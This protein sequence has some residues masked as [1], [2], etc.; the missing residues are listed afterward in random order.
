MT[1]E[2]SAWI[3][4][5]QAW[6]R[7]GEKQMADSPLKDL[8]WV[9]ECDAASTDDCGIR[10]RQEVNKLVAQTQFGDER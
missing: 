4:S 6:W 7:G 10:V 8:P 2:I 3:K 9:L 5:Y 1:R